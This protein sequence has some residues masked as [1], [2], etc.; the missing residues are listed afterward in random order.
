[1]V[2]AGCVVITASMENSRK[3]KAVLSTVYRG[4]KSTAMTTLELL[5]VP[6]SGRRWRLGY[7]AVSL[8]DYH[9]FYLLCNTTAIQT[10]CHEKPQAKLYCICKQENEVCTDSADF[11]ALSFPLRPRI[12]S[13]PCSHL[14]IDSLQHSKQRARLQSTMRLQEESFSSVSLTIPITI[15]ASMR[16]K[17]EYHLTFMSCLQ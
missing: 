13:S 7:L 9:K 5:L 1:M 3:Q 12:S 17:N 2:L 8:C 10:G 6:V 15:T 4:D 14:C 16:G 11:G